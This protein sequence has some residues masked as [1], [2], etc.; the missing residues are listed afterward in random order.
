MKTFRW[1]GIFVNNHVFAYALDCDNM[2]YF[3]ENSAVRNSSLLKK[4][5][6][7]PMVVHGNWQYTVITHNEWVINHKYG[8]FTDTRNYKKHTS[9]DKK[10]KK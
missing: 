6:G 4:L 8:E 7:K 3:I 5:L 2:D 1:R 9:K 10:R